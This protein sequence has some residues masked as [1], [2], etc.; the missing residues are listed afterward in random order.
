MP[1]ISGRSAFLS[2]LRDEGITHLFG[3]PGTTELPIM[4]ALSE[5]PEIN[6]ILG[7]Q[8]AIVVAMADGYSRATGKLSACNV[9]V[10]PG[11]GNA[12]GAIYNAKFVGSPIIIT[13]GQQEQGHGLMEPQLYG[14]LIR[15]AEP[16]VKWAIEVTR[17]EDL[18]RIMRRAAKVALAPPSGP[19]FISLPG[20]ILNTEKNID[21]GGVTRI[22]DNVVPDD[23]TISKIIARIIKATNPMII[24][25]HEVA[26][27]NAFDEIQKFAEIIGAAVYQ[28]TVTHGSHYPSEHENFMGFLP[29]NQ[30]QVKKILDEYDLL[31]CVGSDILRM[32]VWSEDECLPKNMSIL[33]I[34]LRDWEIGK[35]YQTELAIYGHVK[36]SLKKINEKFLAMNNSQF[37]NS[38]KSRIEKIKNKKKFFII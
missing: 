30:S 19:V 22:N 12:I 15:M 14:P 26:C 4:H 10:T 24:S 2:I 18:P 29:K 31:V 35:N 38:A 33:H 25:G 13:A 32:S 23:Q 34:G 1:L 21:L 8:E 16:L 36:S 37:L 28:Q 7:L 17:L 20:D 6:Y 27:T 3:N 11:L 9:H 5:F